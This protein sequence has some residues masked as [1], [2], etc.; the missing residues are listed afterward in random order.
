MG[1]GQSVDPDLRA[2]LIVG[3]AAASLSLLVGFVAR[4]D[5][6]ALFFRALLFALVFGGGTYGLL[7]LVRRF[8]PELFESS[9][10]EPLAEGDP[11]SQTAFVGEESADGELGTEVDIVLGPDEDDAYLVA[12][13][14]GPDDEGSA[15]KTGGSARALARGEES[16]EAEDV[17]MEQE[18]A[19]SL[20]EAG[21]PAS[22]S[23]NG[24]AMPARS[25]TEGEELDILPDLDSLTDSFIAPDSPSSAGISSSPRNTASKSSRKSSGT[26]G[27]DPADLA[28]AVRTLLKRDQKG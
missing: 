21:I 9:E 24:A 22:S 12:S 14:S 2:S 8:L 3:V 26:D 15:P 1:G 27:A 20:V 7:L 10:G 5:L 6:L 11:L 18:G 17:E 16:E 25:S 23:R 4:V 13:G 28:K 19:V